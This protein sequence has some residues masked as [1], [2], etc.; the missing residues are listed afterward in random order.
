MR[1][2]NR[3][4]PLA[5][6]VG[7]SSLIVLSLNTLL[8]V[9][10]L[11]PLALLKFALPGAGAR[12]RIDP[13]LNRIAERWIDNNALWID[14]VQPLS[15]DLDGVTELS[16]SRWYLVEANHQSW[17]DIFVLQRVFNRRIPLLKFFLKQQLIWVPVIGLAWWALDFP[18]MRRHSEVFLKKNPHR[19][20][21]DLKTIRRSCEK[22][23]LVPTAVMN[24]LEGTRF[25]PLKREQGGAPFRHLL[26]PKTG[27][28][29]LALDA[30]GERFHSL[31]DVT[32]FYPAG[33]PTFFEF[34]SGRVKQV[35]VRVR[36]LQIPGDLVGGNYATDPAYRER[37][38]RWVQQLWSEKDLQLDLLQQEYAVAT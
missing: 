13:W 24:F 21:D 3:K 36:E 20:G 25:S 22:F 7:V 23:S 1:G 27:G 37:V 28:I 33:A 5:A 29:A 34:L 9:T 15:I 35:V 38:Q 8:C 12:K 19:R 14:L 4:P 6:L 17:A 18:F 30:M 11:F 31:L 10:A 16:P 32:L 2:V 26:R